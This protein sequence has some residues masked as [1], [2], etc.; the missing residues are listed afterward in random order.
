M[1]KEIFNKFGVSITEYDNYLAIELTFDGDGDK[2][3]LI[4]L[5]KFS[6]PKVIYAGRTYNN[7]SILVIGDLIIE[8]IS[9]DIANFLAVE[10]CDY[11]YGG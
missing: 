11:F 6:K 3:K 8:R 1:E 5:D 10:L 9:V 7:G 2:N 4:Y